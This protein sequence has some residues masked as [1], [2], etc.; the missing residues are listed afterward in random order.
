MRAAPRQE[1]EHHEERHDA[2][3]GL[4]EVA[5]VVV[6]RDLA[7]EDGVLGAHAL[8]DE[9]VADAA[10]ERRPAR[11]LDRLRHGPARTHVVED[12]LARML[13]QDRLGEE[14]GHEVARNELAR[15][16]DEEAA[17]GVAVVRDTEVGAALSSTFATMNSRFSGR[18]GFGSWFGKLPSGS[19]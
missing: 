6:R 3:V 10:H 15:V 11:T 19:K 7:G 18:S 16:V 4:G 13:G 9:G 2:G 8:L 17:V 14:R 5:E 1:L 12:L